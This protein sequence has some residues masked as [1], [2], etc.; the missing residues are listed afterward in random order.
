M[1]CLLIDDDPDDQEIFLMCLN[2][3]LP[4]L[5]CRTCN[6]GREAIDMLA[7]NVS[8]RPDYIFIDVNMP[9]LNGMA[10]LQALKEMDHLKHSQMFMYSTTADGQAISQSKNLGAADFIVKPIRTADLKAKLVGIF[11]E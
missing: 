3:V 2:D 11:A 5:E 6:D 7:S 10:C 9:K 1:Q 4:G 8:Y